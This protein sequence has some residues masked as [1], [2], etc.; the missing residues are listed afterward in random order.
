ALALK[1]VSKEVTSHIL[2]ALTDEQAAAVEEAES[3][4]GRVR[5]SDVEAAQRD[6]IEELSRLEEAG[7]VV[8][9]RPDEMVE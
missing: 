8:I 3:A 9:A 1:G 5:R 2:G 7:E 4:L 6:V